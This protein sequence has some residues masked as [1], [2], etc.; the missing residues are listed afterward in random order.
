MNRLTEHEISELTTLLEMAI[1]TSPISLYTVGVG[2]SHDV[3]R[4]HLPDGEDAFVKVTGAGSMNHSR[5]I[6][7]FLKRSGGFHVFARS[8]LREPVVWEGRVVTCFEWL[9]GDV[10]PPEEFSD[11]EVRSLISLYPA[12]AQRL[13]RASFAKPARDLAAL[14]GVVESFARRH[15]LARPLLAGILAIP[16]EERTYR[17]TVVTHG[18]FQFRNYAFSDGCVSAVFDLDNLVFGSPVEDLAYTVAQRYIRRATK[19][20]ARRRLEEILR[21]FIAASP[22]DRL[23]WRIALNA[24]RLR[25]A[26]KRLEKHPDSLYVA[27]DVWLRDRQALPLLGKREEGRGKREEGKGKRCLL[28]TNHN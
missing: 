23:E 25:A 8:L 20:D 6:I 4:A 19:P 26:A 3:Y 16:E 17:S 15:P 10:K 5:D 21:Q 18:D 2:C 24:C 11:Q 12:L 27:F 1:G 22:H 28:F 14:Y 7:D 13:E 9:G